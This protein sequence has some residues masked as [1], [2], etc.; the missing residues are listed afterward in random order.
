[1]IPISL[2]FEALGPFAEKQKIDF[3][4]LYNDRLFLISGH[5]GSGKTTIFDAITFALFGES[6]GSV[7]QTDSLKSQ[8]ADAASVCYV[9][10]EFCLKGKKYNVH[11][12]PIQL[13][14]RKNQN[15]S[16]SS[17]VAELTL[18]N[19]DIISGPDGVNKY[20]QELL[21]INADQFKK[22]VML[23]QGEFKRFLSDDINE[24]QRILRKIFGTEILDKFTEQLKLNVSELKARLESFSTQYDTHIGGIAWLENDD[25]RQQAAECRSDISTLISLLCEHNRLTEQQLKA[26]RAELTSMQLRKDALNL[27]YHI[28]LNKKYESY[29]NTLNEHTALISK[30]DVYKDIDDTVRRLS[31]INEL[32]HDYFKLAA[33]NKQLAALNEQLESNALELRAVTDRLAAIQANQ[34]NIDA[35]KAEIPTLIKNSEQIKQQ[36]AIYQEIQELDKR[37][38]RLE[39]A[40]SGIIENIFAVNTFREY[41][42]IYWL[43]Q[44]ENEHIAKIKQLKTAQEKHTALSRAFDGL[45]RDYQENFNTFINNQAALLSSTLADNMPC[46]VCGSTSHPCKAVAVDNQVTQEMLAESKKKYEQIALQLENSRAILEQYQA[47]AADTDFERHLEERNSLQARL[48]RIKLRADM[49]SI[50]PPPAVEAI[51]KKILELE[52]NLAVIKQQIQSEQ[53][54]GES[55]K[56]RLSADYSEQA[57]ADIQKR[58]TLINEQCESHSHDLQTALLQKER[59]DEANQQL[60][61][62]AAD[63]AASI[64]QLKAALNCSLESNDISQ[65]QFKADL[66]RLS[67]L[68]AL[69]GSLKDYNDQ[70]SLK[71]AMLH[72]LERELD[73]KERIDIDV[74]QQEVALLDAE[75]AQRNDIYIDI[76]S[77]YNSNIEIQRRLLSLKNEYHQLDIEYSSVNK[78][79][80]VANGKYSDRMNFERYVLAS[81]FND[82]LEFANKRLDLMTSSR[83]SLIRRSEKEKGTKP[84]GLALDVFDSHTGKTRH[85]NT[86]SGGET[87]KVSLAL[88]LGLADIISQGSGGIELNTMFIDEGFGTLDSRSLDSTIECLSQLCESGRYIG[89]ISHVSELKEMISQKIFVIQQ[90]NGSYIKLS[91]DI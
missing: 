22:I 38:D 71:A 2:E 41:A 29:E 9:D 87:F 1:M 47:A 77:K 81:Y 76:C 21:G 44:A 25:G 72:E 36:Q 83:Y 24:K 82:I 14:L 58:I 28:E 6:S 43:V 27:P 49:S 13:R 4:K 20:M 33:D 61:K 86:L 15:V 52:K 56:T 19:G 10:F 59:L 16:R 12:E 62:R 73:G 69:K 80:E 34:N 31:L 54:Q 78:L 88:S 46:P 53:T 75:L 66:C 51:E 7:R 11:R 79:Y 67:E 23:P 70:F 57:L 91:T 5:T 90:P 42:E 8:F 26:D 18:E 63:L 74:L 45:K 40:K 37:K 3:T 60:S 35:I 85:V 32:S 68:E 30:A 17:S 39:E 64:E 55:L 48:S 50:S 89:I 84:S 65:E